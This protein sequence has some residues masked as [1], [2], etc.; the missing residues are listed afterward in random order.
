MKTKFVTFICIFL[1]SICFSFAQS[2]LKSIAKNFLIGRWVL[3]TDKNFV[4][5]LRS[6]SVMYYYKG[7]LDDKYRIEIVFKDSLD[8]WECYFDKVDSSFLFWGKG[9]NGIVLSLNKF[10]EYLGKI[11]QKIFYI[12]QKRRFRI[13]IIYRKCKFYKGKEKEK[14]KAKK[15]SVKIEF[16]AAVAIGDEIQSRLNDLKNKENFENNEENA[17]ERAKI[18][19]NNNTPWLNNSKYFNNPDK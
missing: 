8:C 9:D 7:K 19:L 5:D 2:D 13:C 14:K 18:K 6:D 17:N 3:N 4:M 1:L 16:D 15:G 12:L 11:K 10:D